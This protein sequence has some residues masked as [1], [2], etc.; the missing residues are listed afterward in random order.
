LILSIATGDVNLFC[1]KKALVFLILLLVPT[2]VVGAVLII[3]NKPI[4]T[5]GA[6]YYYL[7]GNAL[8]SNNELELAIKNYEQAVALKPDYEEALND[9]AFIYNSK[10]NFGKAAEALKRLVEIYPAKTIYHY[11]LGVNIVLEAKK[12]N[13]TKIEDLEL[14]LSEFRKASESEPGFMNAKENMVFLE[15]LIVRYYSSVQ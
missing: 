7:K 12:T 8:Y 9:L 5:T 1:I 11:D 15:D 13:K 3:S 14:A 2:L 6:E 10:G 4:D